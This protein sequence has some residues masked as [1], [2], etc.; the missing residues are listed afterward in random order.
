MQAGQRVDRAFWWDLQQL[1]KGQGAGQ[2][3]AVLFCL[4]FSAWEQHQSQEFPQVCR[5]TAAS[6][7]IC[8]EEAGEEP[9]LKPELGTWLAIAGEHLVRKGPEDAGGH[10]GE[11]EQQCAFGQGHAEVFWAV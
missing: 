9:V 8:T 7:G 4:F 2:A 3:L 10:Q 1:G 11:Q 6:P 5:S